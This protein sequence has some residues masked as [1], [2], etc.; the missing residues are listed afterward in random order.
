MQSEH[1]I[2]TI[3]THS[4][5]QQM[6]KTRKEGKGIGKDERRLKEVKGKTEAEIDRLVCYWREEEALRAR[7]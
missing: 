2:T 7:V 3:R 4:D 6:M 5:L 1:Q